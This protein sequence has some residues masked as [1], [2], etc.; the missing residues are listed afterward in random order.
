MTSRYEVGFESKIISWYFGRFHH[1][2]EVEE[3]AYKVY[4]YI[5]IF[6]KYIL[7]FKT[8]NKYLQRLWSYLVLKRKLGYERI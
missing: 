4:L 7:I 6:N 1:C 3:D 2:Y 8:F 5:R